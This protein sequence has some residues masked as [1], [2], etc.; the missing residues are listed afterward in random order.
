MGKNGGHVVHIVGYIDNSQL[1]ANPGTL[2]APAG[3]G[4]GYF[5]IKNSWGTCTGDLGYRYM[6]VDFLT[7]R[8]TG[9]FTVLSESH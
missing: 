5:I 9:V 8:G 1:A 2:I 3:A 7:S 4:G 6:P